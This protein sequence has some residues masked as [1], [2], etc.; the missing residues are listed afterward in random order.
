MEHTYYT[1]CVQLFDDYRT[2]VAL[3]YRLQNHTSNMN[4]HSM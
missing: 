3:V 2:F 1:M 4:K